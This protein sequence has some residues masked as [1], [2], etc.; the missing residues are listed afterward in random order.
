[1]AIRIIYALKLQERNFWKIYGRS[2]DYRRCYVIIELDSMDLRKVKFSQSAYSNRSLHCLLITMV[3][4]KYAASRS[5]FDYG[6][7]LHLS[8]QI[9]ANAT[10]VP[11]S[12]AASGEC[13]Q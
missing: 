9:R 4:R 10:L 13:L 5:K 6:K 1:M 2:N 3:L 8:Q 7:V 11:L 12:S